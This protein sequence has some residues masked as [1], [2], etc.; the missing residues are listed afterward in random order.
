LS[1]TQGGDIVSYVLFCTDA[2]SDSQKTPA[3]SREI[4]VDSLAAAI[5]AA[6]SLSGDG[7]IVWRVLGSE[8]F[9]MER[10]DIEIE[11]ARRRDLHAIPA[12]KSRVNHSR[13]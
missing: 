10:Q 9:R 5:N 13:T 11:R 6:C 1:F 7:V 4:L 3:S 8:G 2:P 12:Q